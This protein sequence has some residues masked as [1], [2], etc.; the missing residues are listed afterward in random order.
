[1]NFEV[2]DIKIPYI[3][4]FVW[5]SGKTQKKWESKINSAKFFLMNN[6]PQL[7]VDS[8]LSE[9]APTLTTYKNKNIG[10][11]VISNHYFCRWTNIEYYKTAMPDNMRD[12]YVIGKYDYQIKEDRWDVLR[13]LWQ[14]A[15]APDCCKEAYFK[16]EHNDPY[17]SLY[18]ASNSIKKIDYRLNSFLAPVG[19]FMSPIVPCSLNCSHAIEKAKLIENAIK[20]YDKEIYSTLK[21]VLEMPLQIDSYRGMVIV[22]TPMFKAVY[23]SDAFKEKKILKIKPNNPELFNYSEDWVVQGNKFPYKGTFSSLL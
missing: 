23:A 5:G 3:T 22:D 9:F 4:R 21:L 14:E 15:L 19:L 16:S 7:M 6:F 13:D 8:G 12:C 17:V 18:G 10:K 20:K 2:H 1:L 11:L